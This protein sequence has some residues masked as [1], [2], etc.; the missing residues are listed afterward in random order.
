MSFLKKVRDWVDGEEPDPL[1]KIAE[2]AQ[3]VL[4]SD[5]TRLQK[6]LLQEIEKTM[7]RQIFPVSAGLCYVPQRFIVF[8]NPT[9]DAQLRGEM[10]ERMAAS[11]SG[12]ALE[13]AKVLSRNAKITASRIAVELR[14]DGTLN[15][16]GVRESLDRS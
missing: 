9:D 16:R 15:A 2:Q 10:R 12:H 11:L 14:L 5:A 4:E 13:R 3:Q 8:L 6:R 7:S 1:E